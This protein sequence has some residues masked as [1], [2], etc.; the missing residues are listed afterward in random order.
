MTASIAVP[1][2]PPHSFGQVI[3][4]LQFEVF[5]QEVI[6]FLAEGG[7]GGRIV[8]VHVGLRCFQGLGVETGKS[9]PV[10]SW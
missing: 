5:G 7:F 2:R 1:P 4:A 10:T 9:S 3:A 8:E 6:G